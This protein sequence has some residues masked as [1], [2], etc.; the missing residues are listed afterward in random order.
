MIFEEIFQG[1]ETGHGYLHGYK[2]DGRKD[3][4]WKHHKINFE[5]HFKTN[6]KGLSPVNE[7]K[8]ACRFICGDVDEEIDP[9]KFCAQVWKINPELFVFKSLGNRWHVYNFFDDWVDAHEA[10]KLAE[11]LEKELMKLSD[12]VDT[13]HT[14]PHYFSLEKNKNIG[15]AWAIDRHGAK[16]SNII[17]GL[18]E[19][20]KKNFRKIFNFLKNFH[21]R[22]DNNSY[23]GLF[24]KKVLHI[25]A[26][27]LRK[28]ISLSK[29]KLKIKYN[30]RINS[31]KENKNYVILNNTFKF[32]YVF[33]PDGSFRIAF[34][35]S[36]PGGITHPEQF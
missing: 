16:Y 7:R 25:R 27:D 5:E 2:P 30:Y 28:L 33:F 17:A 24:T 35:T 19:I 10:R 32:D 18:K 11:E 22:F 3:G 36:Q 34:L 15:G 31:I 4:K 14:L 8:R 1:C 26:S 21:V 29:Q 9:K 13:G 12:E 23:K 20:E 6:P